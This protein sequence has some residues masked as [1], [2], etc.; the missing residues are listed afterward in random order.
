MRHYEGFDD[1][2]KVMYDYHVSVDCSFNY[3]SS[4]LWCVLMGLY[5]TFEIC[6]KD[7]RGRKR[8]K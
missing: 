6:S 3:S 1:F 7:N 8:L 5:E 2:N 4:S